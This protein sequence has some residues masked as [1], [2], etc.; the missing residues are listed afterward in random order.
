M[1]YETDADLSSIGTAVA[2][3]FEEFYQ[4]TGRKIHLE[5]EP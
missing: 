4:E 1:P 5:I 2:D 3:K